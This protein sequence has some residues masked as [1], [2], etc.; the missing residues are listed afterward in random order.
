MSKHDPD[1]H[2]RRARGLARHSAAAR[3]PRRPPAGEAAAPAPSAA[4][5]EKV[6]NVYNWS[7]YIDPKVIEDFQKETGIKVRYDVFDS[8][9]VLETKLLTGNSGYDVVVPSAYFLERQIK[10][11]VF[12]KLDKAQAAEPRQPRPRHRAARRRARPGQ[13][14]RRRL[15]VGHDRHRLRRRQGEGDH[16]ERAGRQLEP[17][18]RSGRDL[19][20]QGLRRLG[21]RGSDRHGRHGAALPRQG[22]Q[23]RVRGGPEA[24]RGAA[25]QDPPV[26]PHDHQ[27]AVHRGARE[28]RDLHRRGLQRRR[29]AGPRPRRGGGQAGRHP[30]LDPEGRRADVVRHAGDSG[31][32][33][34]SRQRAPVHRLPAAARRRG[35]QLRFRQ[36]RERQREG[37]GARERGTA[38]RHRASTRR[39]RRRRGCSRTCRSRPSSR[40]C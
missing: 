12:G 14:V 8:N 10:A 17:G 2:G 22:P 13:R 38:Q 18:L 23:Q 31:R 36:L 40:A 5:E 33:E 7:D 39:P 4:A 16:A 35:T 9:E 30:V 25:A 32:R 29:A 26:H 11:G 20:V 27:L 19:E 6:L 1:G 28:R 24:R 34:A 21:A 3:R 37:H 15:H